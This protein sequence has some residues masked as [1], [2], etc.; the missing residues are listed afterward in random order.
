MRFASWL[1][2][3][4]PRSPKAQRGTTRARTTRFRPCLEGLEDRL[5]PT[6]I[7]ITSLTVTVPKPAAILVPLTN[8]TIASFKETGVTASTK[9]IFTITVNWGDGTTST[10]KA[11]PTGKSPISSWNVTASHT[12]LTFPTGKIT[13]TVTDKG[14]PPPVTNNPQVKTGGPPVLLIPNFLGG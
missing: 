6:G 12:Y 13:V 14:G 7:T 3:L 9:H 1:A 11:V 5:V 8:I 10:G 2:Q 4:L